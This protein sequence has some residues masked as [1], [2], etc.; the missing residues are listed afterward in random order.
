[1]I[2]LGYF[3]KYVSYHSDFFH[4]KI[5]WSLESVLDTRNTYFGCVVGSL[6][7]LKVKGF[8]QNSETSR[9]Y[10]SQ[11][12]F[13][14]VFWKWVKHL[15]LRACRDPKT[16]PKCVLQVSKTLSRLQTIFRYKNQSDTT[17]TFEHMKGKFKKTFKTLKSMLESCKNFWILKQTFEFN[18]FD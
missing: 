3:Q 17:R 8:T 18:P 6:R 9:L 12:Y 11:T 13:P 5:A 16:H 4:W 14:S 2:F 15:A 10:S 1:M 7:A